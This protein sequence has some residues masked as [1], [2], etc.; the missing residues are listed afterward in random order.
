MGELVTCPSC[1]G[2]WVTT[3]LV[4]GLALAP[5][6]TRM[7]AGTS[8]ALTPADFLHFAYSAAEQAE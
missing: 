5:R 6:A 1:I 7:V 8:S 2:Q 4:F 3:G